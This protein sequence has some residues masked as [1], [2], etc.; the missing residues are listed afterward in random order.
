M[1]RKEDEQFRKFKKSIDAIANDN[2]GMV[3]SQQ[4]GRNLV[5]VKKNII[6]SCVSDATGCG[7]IRN[8]FL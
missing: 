7:H 2:V 3:T 6:L 8:I 4:S 1:K 5:Q